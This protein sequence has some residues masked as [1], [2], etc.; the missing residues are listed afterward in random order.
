VLTGIVPFVLL[1]DFCRRI[2][3]AHLQVRTALTLDSA[4]ALLQIGGLVALAAYGL[5]SAAVAYVAVGVASA[6][7]CSVWLIASRRQF[8]LRGDLFT[9]HLQ[10]NWSFGKWVFAAAILSILH[11]YALFWVLAVLI[12]TEAVGV[13]AACLSVVALSNPF[14]LGVGNFLMP[15]AAQALAEGGRVALRRIAM[16]ATFLVASAMTLFCGVVLLFGEELLFVLYGDPYAGHQLTLVALAFGVLAAAV[17]GIANTGLYALERSD[18]DFKANLLAL[19]VLFAVIVVVAAPWGLPGIAL[20]LLVSEAAA[21]VLRW[22]VFLRTA[23]ISAGTEATT[24]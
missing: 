5:L 6:I 19:V 14:V 3:F 7:A 1:R 12:N 20:S 21:A 10:R 24:S 13:F 18:V 22:F 16:K 8:L 2:S 11:G 9:R 4:I 15:R 17:G 23:K